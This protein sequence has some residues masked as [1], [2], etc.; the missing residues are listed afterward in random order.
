M[1]GFLDSV[2]TSMCSSR[3]TETVPHDWIYALKAVGITGSL[4][5]E[6]HLDTGEIPPAVL[7]PH[8]APPE[9]KEA[10]QPDL[11]GLLGPELSGKAEKESRKYIPAHF[12]AFP[13]KHTYMATPVFPQRES[14]PRKVRE[15][16]AQDGIAAENSLRKLMA[17]QKAGLQNRKGGKRKQSER[18]KKTNAMWREAMEASMKQD[19]ERE[20]LE[21][22]QRKKQLE[23]E[24][25]DE[26]GEYEAIEDLKPISQSQTQFERKIN[27]DEPVQVNYERKFWRKNA[28]GV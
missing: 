12:P 3:R 14:D 28:R 25:A 16:A 17:A 7:Q 1:T 4:S 11:E 10:P 8:F 20:A 19:E 6:T 18:M 27:L 13:S 22:E 23:Q 26:D 15:K 9:P 21:K 24:H 5:L 2:R